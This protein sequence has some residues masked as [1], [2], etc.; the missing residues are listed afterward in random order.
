LLG[1]IGPKSEAEEIKQQLRRDR[2]IVGMQ[3]P[4]RNKP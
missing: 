2:S 1:F 4:G 3:G